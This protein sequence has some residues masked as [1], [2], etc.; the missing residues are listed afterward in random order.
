MSI[1]II[2]TSDDQ[3]HMLRDVCTVVLG[4]WEYLA[5]CNDDYIDLT[6]DIRIYTIYGI[7]DWVE[8]YLDEDDMR[9]VYETWS[10]YSGSLQYP[11]GGE[12]EYCYSGE[13]NKY[14]NPSRRDLV[15]WVRDCCDEAIE[16]GEL[17]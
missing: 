5:G 8:R 10:G 16:Y 17:R 7:C 11:V 15:E 12:A 6:L 3:V 2:Y 14:R 4:D 13:N 9:S 1:K